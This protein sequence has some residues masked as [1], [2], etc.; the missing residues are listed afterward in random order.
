MRTSTES[1]KDYSDIIDHPH[2]Q[3]LVH[4]HMS[5]HDRAAQFS[6]F[7]AL[8]GYEDMISE[9]ARI[10]ED[11]SH[12][13]EYSRDILDRLISRISDEIESGNEPKVKL[14]VFTPDEKKQGGRYEDRIETIRKIDTV[15]RKLI[16]KRQRES[17]AYET[18][19]VERISKI[20]MIDV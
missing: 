18:I 7:A 17:G 11:E 8:T 5:L 2:H 12:L 3:S 15:E 20:E 14:T 9:E 10:T 16:L 1:F 4:P 19:D 6:P 13:D